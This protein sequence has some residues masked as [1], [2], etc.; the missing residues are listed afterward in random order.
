MCLWCSWKDLDEHD[1]ME[2]IWYDL[3]DIDEASSSQVVFITLFRTR[4]YS[5]AVRF[6][7]GLMSKL[8]AHMQEQNYFPESN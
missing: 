8:C 2:F 5:F 1:L 7:R 3:G 6:L 4:C